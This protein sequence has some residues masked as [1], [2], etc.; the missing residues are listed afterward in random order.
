M[1][2][3][4][5]QS[6]RL[7]PRASRVK[8]M[9]LKRSLAERVAAYTL[10][11]GAAGLGMMAGVQSADARIVYTAT[12]IYFERGAR[13]D[14]NNDGIT[15]FEI[16]QTCFSDVSFVCNLRAGGAPG[17]GL[18]GYAG[19]WASRLAPGAEIGASGIFYRNGR[20]LMASSHDPGGSGG[21][22]KNGGNG[23]L[24][25]EF[26]IGGQVHYGWAEVFVAGPPPTYYGQ[27]T[28]YAYNTVP[29]QPIR[30]GQ[31]S[32]TDVI[33]GIP[34]QPATL[35]LLAL[36]APGLDIWRKRETA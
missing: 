1:S 20:N 19:G 14:V 8:D 36:G 4:R 7:K 2:K 16:M 35:G 24:G 28:G 21:A 33:G 31:K 23:F 30:A 27:V 18:L 11:A 22:W 10:A 25:L 34:P 26:Q 6:G 32:N 5:R 13:L 15:D 9:E 3:R 12:N 29:N 17:N